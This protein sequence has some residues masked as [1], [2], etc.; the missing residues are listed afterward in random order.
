[1]DTIMFDVPETIIKGSR[2]A[3]AEGAGVGGKVLTVALAGNP[4]AGKTTIFNKNRALVCNGIEKLYIDAVKI[5]FVNG[6]S[7]DHQSDHF[8]I[9]MQGHDNDAL[10]PIRPIVF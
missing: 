8:V 5:R 4:N 10:Y 3:S 6:V 7:C 2:K 1:M 9:T